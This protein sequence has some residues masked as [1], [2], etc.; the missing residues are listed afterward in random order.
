MLGQKAFADRVT[1]GFEM[2]TLLQQPA[3]QHLAHSIGIWLKRVLPPV[4]ADEA[5]RD[6][7]RDAGQ[8]SAGCGCRPR[9]TGGARG[10]TLRV[11]HG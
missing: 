9:A 7:D 3:Y 2:A 5:F 1:D 6:G 11:Q 10:G 8:C 4:T